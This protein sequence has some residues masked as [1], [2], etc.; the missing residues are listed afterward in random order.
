MTTRTG[1]VF[2]HEVLSAADSTVQEQLSATDPGSDDPPVTG[3]C[4]I[5]SIQAVAG[6]G[7]A[8]CMIAG[9]DY[10]RRP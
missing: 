9:V 1:E 6:V 4:T 2:G 10:G 8:G 7:A 3:V 5:Y